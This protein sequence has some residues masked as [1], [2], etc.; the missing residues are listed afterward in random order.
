M[1]V[2][3]TCGANG[4]E[5]R[6]WLLRGILIKTSLVLLFATSASIGGA[7]GT[8]AQSQSHGQAD[9]E[10]SSREMSALTLVTVGLIGFMLADPDRERDSQMAS[11]N[12]VDG[13]AADEGVYA[14]ERLPTTIGISAGF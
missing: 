5:R 12:K 9:D 2:G 6:L 7:A 1:M 14:V 8:T 4:H 11:K 10:V 3:V 13:Y